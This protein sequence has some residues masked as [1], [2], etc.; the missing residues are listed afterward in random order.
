LPGA[1]PDPTQIDTSPKTLGVSALVTGLLM[2]M[3][4]FPSELFDHT[5]K[6]HYRT[7][8]GWFGPAVRIDQR[9]TAALRSWPQ[10]VAFSAFM[11]IGGVLGAFIDPTLGWNIGSLALVLGLIVSRAMLTMTVNVPR[12]LFMRR[13]YRLGGQFQAFPAALAIAVLCVLVSRVAGFEPGYLYGT[14]VGIEFARRL[15]RDEEGVTATLSAIWV[16]AVSLAAWFAWIPVVNAID[17]GNTTFPILFVDAVLASTFVMGIEWLVIVLLPLDVLDGKALLAWSRS[18]WTALYTVGGFLFV[19]VLVHPES[20]FVGTTEQGGEVGP[21][22]VPCIVF[23]AIS[24]VFWLCL[25]NRPPSPLEVEPEA[26][27]ASAG[28]RVLKDPVT[29]RSC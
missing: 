1:F 20:D 26:P 22:L 12:M 8:R 27:P 23:A 28:D 25:R 14:I 4:V 24:I 9:L 13:R 2:L 10:W 6:A 15:S 18:R 29:R 7:V 19:W 5:L 3:L 17:G 21:A 16:L 11:V